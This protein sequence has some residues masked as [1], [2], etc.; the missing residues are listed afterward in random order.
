MSGQQQC[1]Q[2]CLSGTIAN[3]LMEGIKKIY[4]KCTG[5]K[6][7]DFSFVGQVL[8][9]EHWPK[10]SLSCCLPLFTQCFISTLHSMIWVPSINITEQCLKN[11]CLPDEGFNL[12]RCGCS[13]K[14]FRCVLKYSPEVRRRFV[15]NM[16]IFHLLY[17]ARAQGSCCQLLLLRTSF[18]TTHL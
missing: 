8:S 12:E 13:M 15:N 3:F 10:L 5:K 18:L 4:V 6:K 16:G 11:V 1:Y 9:L 7:E 17:P 14:V 2:L